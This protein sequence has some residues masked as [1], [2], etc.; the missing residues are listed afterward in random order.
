MTSVSQ[1]TTIPEEAQMHKAFLCVHWG[2][3]GIWSRPQQS[4]MANTQMA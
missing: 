4:Q 3:G 2:L 1:I